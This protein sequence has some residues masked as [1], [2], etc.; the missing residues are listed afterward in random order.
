MQWDHAYTILRGCF[1]YQGTGN[2]TR[3]QKIR[4]KENYIQILDE[5]LKESAELLLGHYWKAQQD[6][7]PKRT[8]KVIQKS[9]KENDISILDGQNGPEWPEWAEGILI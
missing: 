3:I 1:S 9:L 5:T 8:A 6:N 2:P 7:D 4:R